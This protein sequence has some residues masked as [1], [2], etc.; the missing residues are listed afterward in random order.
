MLEAGIPGIPQMIQSYID[1]VCEGVTD[2]EC[3]LTA[4]GG[5]AERVM[6]PAVVL[7]FALCNL[8]PRRCLNLAEDMCVAVL[9]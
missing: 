5:H 1:V 9:K 3:I 2:N 4:Y 7:P 6:D 8:K